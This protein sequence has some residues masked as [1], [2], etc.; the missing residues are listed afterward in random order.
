[1]ERTRQIQPFKKIMAVR[2]KSSSKHMDVDISLSPRVNS[3]K[4]SKT[5]V[6]TDQ[7][8]ALIQAG[9][10]VIKLTVG[11]PDFNTP[12]VVAEVIFSS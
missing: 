4:P 6:I 9:I 5:V 3:V 10:P 7:A 1:M 11:E 2:A 8:T 12:A